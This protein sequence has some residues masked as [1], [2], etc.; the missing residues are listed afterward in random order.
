MGFI[1]LHKPS[2]AQNSPYDLM[3]DKIMSD[4]VMS[5]PAREAAMSAALRNNLVFD[6][7]RE[8]MIKASLEQE[9]VLG[10][11]E[12]AGFKRRDS[13]MPLSGT[14]SGV[15]GETLDFLNNIFHPYASISTEYTNN[16]FNQDDKLNPS[17]DLINTV[18]PGLK[19]TIGE[20]PAKFSKE[21]GQI[22]SR[23]MFSL[24]LDGGI[25]ER[26]YKRNTHLN[27]IRPYGSWNMIFGNNKHKILFSSSFVK[28]STLNSELT[29]GASGVT[30]NTIYNS[31][32]GYGIDFSRMDFD[33]KY[34]YTHS[35]YDGAYGS[36]N[37]DDQKLWA[38]MAY[39]KPISMPKTRFFLEFDYGTIEYLKSGT[40]LDNSWYYKFFVGIDGKITAKIKGNMKFGYGRKILKENNSPKDSPS[41]E[42][43]LTY[44]YDKLTRYRLTL[45]NGMQESINRSLTTKSYFNSVIGYEHDLAFNPKFSLGCSLNLS[46]TKYSSKQNDKVVGF[47]P[48][49]SYAF[50]KWLKMNLKYTFQKQDSNVS[51]NS[52]MTNSV[53]FSANSEF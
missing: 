34:T 30:G 16:L 8:K 2:F 12:K 27:R 19:V 48:S 37:T 33:T 17:Y 46:D 43:G 3:R 15:V 44:N 38:L 36:S 7:T 23:R 14:P 51:Y 42:M 40:N 22:E 10:S 13:L 21:Y 53:A 47:T 31:N 18:K 26:F 29:T 9:E 35:V 20:T 4:A 28:F 25:D 5:N 1:I 41:V 45:Y 39:I 50:R 52:P 11:I 49:L 6:N 24:V 32:I